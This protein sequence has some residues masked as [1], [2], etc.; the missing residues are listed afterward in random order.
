MR[1]MI[2]MLLVFLASC[3]AGGEPF[4][5]NVSGTVGVNSNT[6]LETSAQVSATNGNLTIGVGF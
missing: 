5:T 2:P 3:G 4:K 1:V 6:G